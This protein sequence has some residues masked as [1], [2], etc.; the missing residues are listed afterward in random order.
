MKDALARIDGGTDGRDAKPSDRSYDPVSEFEG[1]KQFATTLARGLE[2][3]RCFTPQTPILSNSEL[4]RRTGLTKPTIS[5]FTYTLSRLGYLRSDPRHGKYQLGSAVLSLSYPL[6][7]NIALRQIVRPMMNELADYVR[8]SVSMGIRDRLNI[9]YVETSRSYSAF[10]SQL[11]DIGMS[12]P[13]AGSAIGRAYLAGCDMSERTALLNEIKVKTPADWERH[14]HA[15]AQ[16]LEQFDR[17]GFCVSRGEVR[18]EI[19]GVGVP[20]RR[21]TDGEIIVFNCVVQS[22]MVKPNMLE[23]DIGPRLAAMVRTLEHQ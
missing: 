18:S 19:H 22:F 13:I 12:H 11:S 23:Q 3:L 20:M 7:A 15:I 17:H 16:S 6:L 9:V 1:D 21:R 14:Q 8:G 5:R 10:H 2:I 4:S